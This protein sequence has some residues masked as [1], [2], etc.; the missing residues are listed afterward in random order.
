MVEGAETRDVQLITDAAAVP[1]AQTTQDIVLCYPQP[2]ENVWEIA[3]RYRVP[4]SE[5]RALN[6]G[7]EEMPEQGKGIVVWRRKLV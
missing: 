6:P 7:L 2:G 5:L 3:K 1:A 4:E